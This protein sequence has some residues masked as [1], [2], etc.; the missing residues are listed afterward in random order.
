MGIANPFK[1][2]KANQMNPNIQPNI[3]H[4]IH[5]TGPVHSGWIHFPISI[6]ESGID[7]PI[8]RQNIGNSNEMNPQGPILT[9][10]PESNRE[11]NCNIF[12]FIRRTSDISYRGSMWYIIVNIES[13]YLRGN[14]IFENAE[15]NNNFEV[16]KVG[17]KNS[18]IW[19]HKYSDSIHVD[20]NHTNFN[21]PVPY[22]STRIVS[23]HDSDD[24]YAIEKILTSPV[25]LVYTPPLIPASPIFLYGR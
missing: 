23:I 10:I 2:Y 22:D 3:F 12:D 25:H 20:Q 8:Y 19:N 15:R 4:L 13:K 6:L 24:I 9:M 17:C 5:L 1:T 21:L 18:V 7:V 14:K 16:E 11:N